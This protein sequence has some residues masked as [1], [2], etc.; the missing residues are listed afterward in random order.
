MKF[1]Q[2]VSCRVLPPHH[3]GVKSSSA[4]IL[5][6]SRS[7]SSHSSLGPMDDLMEMDFSRSNTGS[8]TN[9]EYANMQ[10]NNNKSAAVSG[11]VEMKPGVEIKRKVSATSSDVSPYVDMSGGAY[12]DMSG[13]SPSRQNLLSPQQQEYSSFVDINR[14]Y[15]MHSNDHQ[16]QNNNYLDMEYRT[17]AVRLNFNINS[18]FPFS[19]LK[20]ILYLQ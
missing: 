7:H 8:S 16:P 13:S 3:H 9:S 6:N 15:R 10:T 14:Q 4:P 12:M 1:F 20:M 2:Q 19:K 5:S 18:I 17:R 11:Y